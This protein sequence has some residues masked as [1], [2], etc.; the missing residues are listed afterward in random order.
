M[1]TNILY[2]LNGPSLSSSTAVFL[3]ADLQTCAP[4]G[5]YYDGLVVREQTDCVL[6]PVQ[7]CPTCGATCGTSNITE[8]SA[9]G[10][11]YINVDL[12]AGTGAVAVKFY[13]STKPTG[14]QAEYNSI[15]YNKFNSAT[16]GILEGDPNLPT[17]MGATSYDCG[18]VAGSPYNLDRYDYIAGGF[19]LG[20]NEIETVVA[21]QMQLTTIGPSL[22]TMIVPKV[23]STVNSL[24]LK[25]LS[26]CPSSSFIINVGCPTQL[27]WYNSTPK[28]TGVEPDFCNQAEPE[29]FYF[30]YPINGTAGIIDIGDYV[31]TDPNGQFPLANGTYRTNL[32]TVKK[33]YGVINGI[34]NNITV[35]P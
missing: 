9:N 12:G 19:V 30:S 4:N 23:D 3:D 31:Y 10:V 28:I 8:Y 13:A 34:V 15:I 7:N 6:G 11:Y 2:Y 35:C 20:G 1:P 29:Y 18:I 17:F 27:P 16:E 21:G 5:F 14:V 26:I 32:G 24:T 22:C 33:A 25:I